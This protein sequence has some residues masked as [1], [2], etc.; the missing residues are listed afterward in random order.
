MYRICVLT[1]DGRYVPSNVLMSQRQASMI[2][3]RLL[4]SPRVDDVEI[5]YVDPPVEDSDIDKLIDSLYEW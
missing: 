4:A 2:A 3:M 5:E 1:R